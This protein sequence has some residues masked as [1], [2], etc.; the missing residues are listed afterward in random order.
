MLAYR[1]ED[2]AALNDAAAR[3]LEAAGHR[4]DRVGGG[5]VV[6]AVGD[7]VRCRINDPRLGLRNGLRGIIAAVDSGAVPSRSTPRT[8]PGS[9]FR[10]TTAWRRVSSM[11]GRSP[12]TPPRA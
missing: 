4:G 3:A 2:V 12:G 9:T 1:R 10:A 6:Y 5:H 11:R 8:A 7:C